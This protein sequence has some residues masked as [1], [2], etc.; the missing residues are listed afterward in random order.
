MM[1]SLLKKAACS[2]SF[3]T[4]LN[5]YLCQKYVYRFNERNLAIE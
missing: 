1:T 2:R 4:Y 3:S 5:L